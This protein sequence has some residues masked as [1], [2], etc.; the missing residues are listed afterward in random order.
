MVQ[1]IIQKYKLLPVQL[2]ATAWFIVCQAIQ[3]G[4]KF[5]TMPF[6]V[7]LLTPEEYGIYNVFLSWTS[8]INIFA[9]LNLHFG[10]YN[11]AMLKYKDS[12]D[13]Y[14]A[15]SQS[16]SITAT[17]ICTVIYLLFFNFW[18]SLFG[19]EPQYSI[20]IF[21]QLLFTEGYLLWSS[22]QRYE[23]KYI[24]LFVSTLA[25]SV[26]YMVIPITAVY[27]APNESRL[28]IAIFA[29][30]AVQSTFGGI[31][32]IYNYIKG[33][34]F[35]QK[36]YWKYALGF[37]IPLIPHYLSGIVLG[38]A[39]RVMIKNI[40]GAAKAGI[41]SF[42]Y[43]I[44]MVINIITTSINN[45]LV[46]Y[47]YSKLKGRDFKALKSIANITLILV[48]GM[49]LAF[50][51]IAPEFI[52]IFATEEYYEAVYLV[53]VIALSSYFTF[54]Y[55]LCGNVEFFFEENKFITVASSIGAVMNIILNWCL[56]PVFGYFA[57][58]YT[59]LFCYIMFALAHYGFMR[60]VCR[61]YLNGAKVYDGKVILALSVLFVV[62]SF[63]MML[64]YDY[65][66][67]R[68]IL[69]AVTMIILFYKRQMLF[70]LLKTVKEG[71]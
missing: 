25:F 14:T 47:E 17:L 70:Q 64:L 59:T 23:Y 54:L 56:I 43:N 10:V 51:A 33:K 16:I 8:I 69:I 3:S 46:P 27:I 26:F 11:N 53:P 13:K 48:G 67:I 57:A 63:G 41:Y 28:S 29:G 38:Q 44:S 61:K 49:V 19:L 21:V 45:A 1:K 55:N 52:K 36:E 18:N 5:F 37:N 2:K 24:A 39:D 50:S 62:L 35:Y 12:R 20:L 71:K 32:L 58:G 66:F 15:S 68:Y 34:C 65:W 31:F 4:C 9:T 30:V 40:T 60:L 42:T 6:L 22:R 7:R